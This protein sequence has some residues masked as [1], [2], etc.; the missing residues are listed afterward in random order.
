MSRG[1]LEMA[2]GLLVAVFAALALGVV[3]A[4]PGARDDR[5]AAAPSGAAKAERWRAPGGA[6]AVTLPAGWQVEH[7]PA[8]TVIQRG[9][10]RGTL[11]VRRGR[12]LRVGARTL[13]AGLER[14]LRER[15]GDIRPLR[16]S[17]LTTGGRQGLLYTFTRPAAGAV[18]SVAVIPVEGATYTLDAVV[19]GADERAARE[20]GAIVRSFDPA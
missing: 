13:A 14:R 7:G 16:A 4:G 8:A 18:Q 15:L 17:A 1:R 9:D 12:E 3:L 6:Y 5:P 11:V 2:G 19:A 10:R 20:V